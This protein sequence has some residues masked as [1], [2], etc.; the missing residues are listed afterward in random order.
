MVH[1][2]A[3]RSILCLFIAWWH[4]WGVHAQFEDVLANYNTARD[5]VASKWSPDI[6]QQL[7]CNTPATKGHVEKMGTALQ[8]PT[9]GLTVG[10]REFQLFQPDKV[11]IYSGCQVLTLTFI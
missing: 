3:R 11:P 8:S 2:L 1:F 4:R 5:L 10:S 9:V 7:L 6:G